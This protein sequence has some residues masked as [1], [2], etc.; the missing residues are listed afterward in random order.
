MI[1]RNYIFA[2]YLYTSNYL[3]LYA[4]YSKC[5]IHR[6]KTEH[7]VLLIVHYVAQKQITNMSEVFLY[8]EEGAS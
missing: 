6:R 2:H 5:D 8:E 4:V 7:F 1:F 3:I